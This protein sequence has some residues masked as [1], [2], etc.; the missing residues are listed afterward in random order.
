MD[1]FKP[2][3]ADAYRSFHLPESIAERLKSLP[4]QRRIAVLSGGHC[5]DCHDFLPVFVRMAEVTNRLEVRI[6]PRHEHPELARRFATHG[7][8]YIPTGVVMDDKC[9][10]LGRFVERPQLLKEIIASGENPQRAKRRGAYQIAAADEIL[11]LL[12]TSP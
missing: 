8:H 10:E 7:K 3:F 12:F 4:A 5:P 11:N 6:F 9:R 2:M 1:Q